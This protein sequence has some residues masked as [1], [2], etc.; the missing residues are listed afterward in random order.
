MSVD[1]SISSSTGQVL[2]LTVWN[3]EMCLGVAVLLGQTEID[4]VDLVSTLA[5]AHEEVIR[6]DVTV[7][8]GFG[9]DILNAGNELISQE[10]DSLQRELS[11]TE[12][13]KIFQTGAEKV[14]NHGIV[15][16]LSTEPANKR[17]ADTASKGLVD[18]GLIL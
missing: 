14:K 2:V 16:A 11:V 13:E 5:N 3:V 8:E 12:V 17:D 7:N 9:V 10:E 1:G 15:V 18:A 4:N 6:F